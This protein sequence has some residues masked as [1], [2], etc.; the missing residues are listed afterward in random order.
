MVLEVI[1]QDYV[2]TAR[3]KGLRERAVV[4]RHILRNALIPVMTVLGL[5]IPYVISGAVVYESIFVVP[6]VGR[7]LLDAATH[8]DYPV[9]QAIVLVMT[10]IVLVSNLAIDLLY[11]YLDPRIR[12][13]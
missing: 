8:R 11:S 13:T 7:F 1:Q 10:A 4:W 6:G 5:Y 3:A 2:R 12:Y 9:I